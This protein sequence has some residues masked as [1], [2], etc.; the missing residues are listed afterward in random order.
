MLIK[1]IAEGIHGQR[2]FDSTCPVFVLHII[3]V[4]FF[5]EFTRA[6]LWK[7]EVTQQNCTSQATACSKIVVK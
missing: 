2:K 5:L 6:V 3:Y 7:L 4:S 1:W